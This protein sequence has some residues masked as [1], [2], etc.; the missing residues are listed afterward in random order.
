MKKTSRF[1]HKAGFS[2]LELLVIFAVLSIL[3]T[4]ILIWVR[5]NSER[6]ASQAAP[7]PETRATVTLKPRK[8]AE[9][10]PVPPLTSD[11]ILRLRKL[12]APKPEAE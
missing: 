5:S 11:E 6:D 7:A 4:I 9:P 1:R 12:I 2:L 10:D 8:A 3:L